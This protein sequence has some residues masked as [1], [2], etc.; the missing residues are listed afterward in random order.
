MVPLALLHGAML[1]VAPSA[2]LIAIGVW[3]NSNTISHNFIHRPFF[4]RRA[5]NVIFG[6]YLSVLL[7]VPQAWWRAR[8]LAH[9]GIA[10]KQGTDV[11]ELALQIV[12]ILT[13]WMAL[14]AMVPAFF[15]GVYLPGYAAGLLLCAL[16]G[17][18]E[19][20]GGTISHYG[21]LYNLLCFNDGYHVEHHRHPG[22]SWSRLPAYRHDRQGAAASAWPAPLRWIEAVDLVA[23]ERL[24][25]R[26]RLLQR[27]M[28]ATH[29]R[30]F[31][32]ACGELPG[33]AR[34]AIVGGGLFP[35]TA[36]VLKRLAPRARLTIIDA[37]RD[38]LDRARRLLH[39]ERVAFVHA[40]Y[41]ADVNAGLLDH[42][43]PGAR[44][45]PCEFDILVVP[46]A[47]D[48]DRDAI[49][50]H[51]PAGTVIVH[52]WIWNKR[53][54]SRVVSPLLLKRINVVCRC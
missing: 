27:F 50:A 26:S 47:F 20:A 44:G 49:Y 7:G 36:L 37:N 25:L 45:R 34:I 12:L 39:D 31:R 13:G 48:G 51:P 24:V 4:R 43:S 9:H 46:L 16:H 17:H 18:Y 19:H 21:A 2:P 10:E 28:V 32:Q 42:R 15:V 41:E 40:R 22:V 23:L 5:A 35:R 3:W 11:G 53:G 6:A 33:E 52:D 30:A 8:H 54:T 1:A 29:A 14:G 38:H